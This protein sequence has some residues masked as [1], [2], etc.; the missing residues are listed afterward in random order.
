MLLANSKE[1]NSK[2]NAK[3]PH[4]LHFYVFKFYTGSLG[5]VLTDKIPVVKAGN[6]VV[7]SPATI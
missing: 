7:W 5:D 2:L 4:Y 3:R 1:F 6:I